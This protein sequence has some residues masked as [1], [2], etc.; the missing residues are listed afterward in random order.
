MLRLLALTLLIWLSLTMTAQAQTVHKRGIWPFTVNH[1]DKEGRHHGRWKLYLSDN[2]TLLRNGRFKH[3]EERGKWKYYYPNGGIRKIEY[4][5]PHTKEFLVKFF[6]DNGEVEKQGMARVVETERVIRYY[7]FGT[8][9]VYNRAGQ[10]T[11]TEY[12]EN[13]NEMNL[14]LSGARRTGIV[15]QH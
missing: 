1:F 3:G 10:L 9:Q 15:A 4:H 6:H 5:K 11:H 12:Y 14:S 8:W 7:W 2:K 13:G